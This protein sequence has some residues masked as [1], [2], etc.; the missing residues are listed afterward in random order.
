VRKHAK[1]THHI[2]PTVISINSDTGAPSLQS[3]VP[4]I[5][6][7]SSSATLAPAAPAAPSHYGSSQSTSHDNNSN[8]NGS[9]GHDNNDAVLR[10]NRSETGPPRR[11]VSYDDL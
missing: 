4:H 7:S 3:H 1:L 2:H 6:L 8:N 5:S 9:N 11:V 10:G